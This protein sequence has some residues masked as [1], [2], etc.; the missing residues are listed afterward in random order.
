MHRWR[1]THNYIKQVIQSGSSVVVMGPNSLAHLVSFYS[2]L[3][4][5]LRKPMCSLAQVHVY[6]K[7][8]TGSTYRNAHLAGNHTIAAVQGRE[9]YTLFSEEA[10]KKS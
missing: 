2:P 6:H 4:F 9:D 8:T 3:E 10:F 1:T 7:T 5:W